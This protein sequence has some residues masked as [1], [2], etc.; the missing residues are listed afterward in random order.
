M[1]Q[2]IERYW[3]YFA[4]LIGTSIWCYGLKRPHPTDFE[5]LLSASCAAS[6][7]LVGFLATSKTILIS[8]SSSE[9]YLRIKNGNYSELLLSYFFWSIIWGVLFLCLSIVGFF[10]SN[11]SLI[12]N[13]FVSLWVFSAF[14]SIFCFLRVTKIMF[15]VMKW[16]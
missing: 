12:F 4:A 8:I 11:T 9:V 14:L 2:F 5:S 10:V 1:S 7:V 6:A 16:V 3:P 13:C 15:S